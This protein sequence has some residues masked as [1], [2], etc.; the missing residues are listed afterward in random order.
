MNI[1]FYF[2]SE[3]LRSFWLLI[4]RVCIIDHDPKLTYCLSCSQDLP[5]HACHAGLRPDG[6]HGLM[7]RH[8]HQR[9]VP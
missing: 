7:Y 6:D 5:V 9:Q 1:F 4:A 8:L 3:I 2:Q